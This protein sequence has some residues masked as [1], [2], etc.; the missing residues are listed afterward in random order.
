MR[1]YALVLAALWLAA[2]PAVAAELT[3]G[4][5]ARI[6]EVVD[7]D[8]VV[9]E[10][11]EQV[12]MV[13][14]Q[15]PKLPLGRPGFATWPLAGEAKGALEALA[16]D[17][18]VTLGYGGRRMDRHGRL[19]AHLHRADGL[20]LQGEM[21]RLGLARVYSF[22]DNRALVPE[23]L[24]LEATA[25]G[26]RRGIWAHRFYAVRRAEPGAVRDGGFELVVGRVLD[27]AERRQRSYLNF[28]ADWKTDFTVSIEKRH[29]RLFEREGW[30]LAALKGRLVRVRGWVKRFNGPLIEVTHPEQ[31]ELL[32]E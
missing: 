19:L 1:R 5:T 13:G 27:V 21:L 30:D 2:Q 16:M 32:E 4:G 29:R 31:I 17:R 6:V 9:L 11:G 8:T 3:A 7:G 23:M 14:I 26:A 28:G 10:T 18:T 12:R 25:R 15:A 20:W 24:A 22:R